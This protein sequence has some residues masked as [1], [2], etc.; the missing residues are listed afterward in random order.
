MQLTNE[1]LLVKAKIQ[2]MQDYDNYFSQ[3]VQNVPQKLRISCTCRKISNAVGTLLW[4][5]K[6][7]K[8]LIFWYITT[9]IFYCIQVMLCSI[10][11]SKYFKS[12]NDLQFLNHLRLRLSYFSKGSYQDS[13]MWYKISFKITFWVRALGA[14]HR[15]TCQ[16]GPCPATIMLTTF[17]LEA[18]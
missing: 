5:A 18:N 8:I 12:C 1:I 11:D 15:N 14:F 16:S 10:S 6:L 7:R 2:S 17:V 13:P 9:D 3:N 4:T